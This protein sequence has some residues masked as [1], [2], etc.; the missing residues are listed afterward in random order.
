[1]PKKKAS[2]TITEG[3]INKAGV[4]PEPQEP[5]PEITAKG[6]TIKPGKSV[7]KT[8]IVE[9]VAEE[10]VENEKKLAFQNEDMLDEALKM[11]SEAVKNSR[12]GG[13]SK[14][15]FSFH[16]LNFLM[17]IVNF[18]KSQIIRTKQIAET[19]DNRNSQ[20]R[21]NL[22]ALKDFLNFKLEV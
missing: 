13:F 16:E 1:M 15:E 12:E 11:L 8:P 20:A 22:E 10:A 7:T 17:N 19:Y 9:E 21:Q 14:K 18:S 6:Q 2:K 5:K 4:N 3:K